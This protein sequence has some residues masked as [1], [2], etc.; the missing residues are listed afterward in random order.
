MARSSYLIVAGALLVVVAAISVSA[1]DDELSMVTD[2]REEG[3]GGVAAADEEELLNGGFLD[4]S[5]ALL[6]VE[7]RFQAFMKKYGKSYSG[8]SYAHR[9]RVFTDNLLKAVEHQALD[10]GAVHGITKFSDLTEEEF[11]TRYTGLKITEGRK[12][13]VE[14]GASAPTLPTDNLPENFDWRDFGAVTDVKDQGSCGSCW[15][16]S[17]AGGLESANFLATGNLIS[18]SE[19]QLV[20]CDHMCDAEDKYACDSGC[21]GGLMTTA[22]EYIKSAGGLMAQSDYKYTGVDGK[23]KFDANKIKVKVANFTELPQADEEQMAAYLVNY[24]PLSVGINAAF[25]QTYIGG[26]SC[27][28]LCNKRNLDHGVLIVGYAERGFAPIR[29]GYKPYWIIKNSWGANWGDHGY[30]K[31]C[32]GYNEC[33][34]GAMVSSVAT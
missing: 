4:I 9:L 25:M 26:V 34:V 6:N 31:I 16:F 8:E 19:Q 23:C 20:D 5:T 30:Y 2:K 10:L 7:A 32:R 3:N 28:L 29:L 22:F 18:L 15:A 13:G 24:G 21:N 33:G 11:E 17:A 12:A 14:S 1:F 27:P